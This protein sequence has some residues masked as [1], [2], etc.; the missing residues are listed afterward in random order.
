MRSISTILLGGVAAMAMAGAALA[1]DAAQ[2]AA[3][4]PAGAPGGGF[5]GGAPR[6]N[7]PPQEGGA[8]GVVSAVSAKGFTVLM[9]TD[10]SVDV[11]L[12]SDTTFRKGKAPATKRALKVGERVRVLG[13]VAFGPGGAPGQRMS[14][15]LTASHVVLNPIDGAGTETSI[16]VAKAVV[17]VLAP[18]PRAPGNPGGQAPPMA[19]IRGQGAAGPGPGAAGPP[20]QRPAGADAP[21]AAHQGLTVPAQHIGNLNPDWGDAADPRTKIAAG[22]EADKATEIAMAQPYSSGGIVDRVV[23]EP[24]GAYLVH[25]IGVS[26]PHHIFVSADFKPVGAAN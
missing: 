10:Q 20:G 3:Q 19:Q 24:D 17:M 5:R 6:P 16:A 23:K 9:P 18:V 15:A 26:W 1:Q 13:P 25:N 4:A 7:H 21:G 8:Y 12:A 22:A 14:M 11:T 2:P